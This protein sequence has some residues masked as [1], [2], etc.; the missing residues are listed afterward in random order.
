M[1]WNDKGWGTAALDY[2]EMLQRVRPQSLLVGG[3]LPQLNIDGD[4]VTIAKELAILITLH[5]DIL[6]NGYTPVR[7]VCEE[8]QD[9]HAIELTPEG[10]RA[11]A[12]EIC[13]FITKRKGG[14]PSLKTDIAN[15]YLRGLEGQWGLQPLRGISTSPILSA[16]GSI[17]IADGYDE[18]TGLWCHSIPAVE[19]PERPTKDD[20]QQAL[21]VL[22]QA[23]WTFPFSDAAT[24]FDRTLRVNVVDLS[25][26]PNL[27][28]STHLVALMTA[29]CRPCL[30][31]APGFLYDA[32]GFSGAGTGKGLLVKSACIIGHGS[33][34]SAMTAGHDEAELD[35]RLIASAIEARPAIFLDNFNEGVLQSA[36]LASFLTESPARVRVLGQSKT[37]LLNT[38][39]FVAITGNAVQIA[40]DIARRIL[41]ICLDA[42]MENPEQRP[43]AG[44][45]LPSI[46]DRRVDL[47][48]ACLTIWRWG[49]EQRD[50]KRG[51]PLG[52]YEQWAQWCRDSLL[53]LGCRDP[54]ERVSQIKAAD[55]KRR[56]VVEVFQRWWKHHADK[57]VTAADLHLEVK[58][59]IDP[60]SKRTADD[61]LAF[62]R[63]RV[64]SFLRAHINTRLGG[65]VLTEGLGTTN[66]Q[67]NRV[68]TY[69]LMQE[70]TP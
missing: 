36:T 26:P 28:E 46:F 10:V 31:L 37:V 60:N 67:R 5:R 9:P 39:A 13:Q 54:V 68:T 69:R 6:L 2:H 43:F 55:P 14:K 56:Y 62:S 27:D 17:R 11:Y 30:P 42:K 58:E 1:N 16:D 8:G 32:P 3:L 45:F 21:L 29:V 66:E 25:Q 33:T 70:P 59:A 12:S 15:I 47:L 44:G 61:V 23:F 20:A 63:Q 35:K 38:C 19:I 57:D 41:K 24:V 4:P 49:V 65:F 50:L 53:A 18:E 52:S 48:T 40:E 34:P 51:L 7:V 64:A 22:R